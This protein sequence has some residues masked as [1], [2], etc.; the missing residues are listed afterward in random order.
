[1]NKL[2]QWERW[3]HDSGTWEPIFIFDDHEPESTVR[4][5]HN[6]A[7]RMKKMTKSATN[8]QK[9]EIYLKGGDMNG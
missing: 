6:R 4:K 7:L 5:T 9:L 1:M 2:D 3:K 8:T